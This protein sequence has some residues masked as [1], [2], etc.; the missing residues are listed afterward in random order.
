MKYQHA[1]RMLGYEAAHKRRSSREQCRVW[2]RHAVHTT[3]WFGKRSGGQDMSAKEIKIGSETWAYEIEEHYT[4]IL[5]PDGEPA[6]RLR[7][8]ATEGEV[9]AAAYGFGAGQRIGRKIGEAA[10]LAEIQRVL[11]IPNTG[12]RGGE[13]VP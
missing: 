9:R 10:N 1:I 12:R 8:A 7:W 2:R 11:C 4:Y 5:D 13:A 3:G 6:L